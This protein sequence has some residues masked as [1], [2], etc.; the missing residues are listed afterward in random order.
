MTVAAFLTVETLCAGELTAVK[1]PSAA[2]VAVT[3]QLPVP[4]VISSLAGSLA[5]I[6]QA[7]LLPVE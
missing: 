4:L 7:V 3:E 1:L 5:R 6:W 2:F